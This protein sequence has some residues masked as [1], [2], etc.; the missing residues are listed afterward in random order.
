MWGPGL[1]LP[2]GRRTPH[3]FGFRTQGPSAALSHQSI[4]KQKP[5]THVYQLVRLK[6]VGH[7][8]P[9]DTH[10]GQVRYYERDTFASIVTIAP[11]EHGKT[12]IYVSTITWMWFTSGFNPTLPVSTL[13]GGIFMASP[14]RRCATT[15][16]GTL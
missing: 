5:N 16:S 13:R 14:P 4:N 9:W 2:T 6:G 15:P 1:R 7:C 12:I 11:P 8:C 3:R 10:A